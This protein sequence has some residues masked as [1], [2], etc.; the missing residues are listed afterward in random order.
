MDALRRIEKRGLEKKE[1]PLHE[2]TA[3]EL[4]YR[5]E[6]I[7]IETRYREPASPDGAAFMLVVAGAAHYHSKTANANGS[8]LA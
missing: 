8:R 2:M 5:L 1:L 4:R 7:Q 6:A 3:T